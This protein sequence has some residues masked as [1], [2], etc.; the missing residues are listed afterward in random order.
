M[1]SRLLAALALAAALTPASA[2][3]TAL[4][5]GRS[6]ATIQR[7]TTLAIMRHGKRTAISIQITVEGPTD[8]ALVIVPLPTPI[9]PPQLHGLS[10]AVFD[11]L[12]RRSAPRLV[13]LWEQPPCDGIHSHNEPPRPDLGLRRTPDRRHRSELRNIYTHTGSPAGYEPDILGARD[14][15]HILRWLRARDR[16]VPPR[17]AEALQRLA[18]AGTSFLV[19]R[20]TDAQ[21]RRDPHGRAVLPPFRVDYESDN[22]TLPLALLTAAPPYDL[23]VHV[24]AAS[25]HQ[26]V[27][28]P[29]LVVPS[30][31]DVTPTTRDAF[32]DFYGALLTRTVTPGAVVTEHAHGYPIC[33]FCEFPNLMYIELHALGA[34]ALWIPEQPPSIAR[35]PDTM[36]TGA[37]A[38]PDDDPFQPTEQRI[39]NKR[40]TRPHPEG[41]LDLPWSFTLTRLRL[42]L[43]PDDPD[44]TL[45]LYPV[46]PS[47][48]L[49]E[50]R[51]EIHASTIH[52]DRFYPHYF[53]KHPW[54]GPIACQAP[55]RGIWGRPPDGTTRPEP[56]RVTAVPRDTPD[57][58][59]EFFLAV[60]EPTKVTALPAAYPPPLHNARCDHSSDHPP[61][62][63]IFFML[64]HRRRRGPPP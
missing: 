2:H 12:D 47:P 43:D 11:R 26:A 13:E 10:H 57:T 22:L 53:I 39:L 63:L 18:D 54:I 48:T 61:L 6:E 32:D 40:A 34:S 24:I 58:P 45:T 28:R 44:S 25:R 41:S 23:V 16:P 21:V 42:R 55:I 56:R 51:H 62:A 17:A 64:L 30:A 50:V 15:R 52:T 3:A 33:H 7:A 31:L 59:L 46:S 37:I 49:G 14:S 20:L 36:P 19:L 5:L 9:Q 8:D 4:V 60:D 29:N 27:G 35:E 38:V 1:S